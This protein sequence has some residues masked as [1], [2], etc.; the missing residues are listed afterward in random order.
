MGG[1]RKGKDWKDIEYVPDLWVNCA[2]LLTED[3]DL[4][5]IRDS[6]GRLGGRLRGARKL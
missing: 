1:R 6:R 4:R 5:R 3:D 2:Q